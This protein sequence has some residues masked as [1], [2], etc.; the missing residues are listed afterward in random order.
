MALGFP[1]LHAA[2]ELGYLLMR[3]DCKV[4]DKALEREADSFASAFLLPRVPFLAEGPARLSWPRLRDMK[5]RWGVSLL[6]LVRRAYDLGVY[7]E[8]TYRRAHVEYAQQGWR[9]DGEPD[10]PPMELPSLV[11]RAVEQLAYFG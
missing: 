7:S 9:A 2:R 6:A 5:R 11:T 1:T 3:A 10:E 4:G 8:A